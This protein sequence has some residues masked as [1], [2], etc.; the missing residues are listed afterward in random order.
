[1]NRFFISDMIRAIKNNEIFLTS[2]QNIARDYIGPLEFFQIIRAVLHYSPMNDVIDCY[3]LAPIEKIQLL[4]IM[5]LKFGLQYKFQEDFESI[6]ATGVKKNYYSLNHRA[7]LYGYKPTRD[8]EAILI[9]EA[10]KII[11]KQQFYY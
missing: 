9:G 4:N 1:L 11:D 8:S 5:T 2:T 3:T 6:N 7:A 10:N